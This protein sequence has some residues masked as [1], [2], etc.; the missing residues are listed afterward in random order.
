[1][2]WGHLGWITED[3]QPRR[4]WGFT[5]TLGYSRRMIAVGATD[6]KVWNAAA[7]ARVRVLRMGRCAGADFLDRMKTIWTGTE[8]RGEIVWTRDGEYRGS[9]PRTPPLGSGSSRQASS[10]QD[11]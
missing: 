4:L 7:H 11:P 9:H 5:I 1:M 2:D 8:E 3:S 10:R 6:Q